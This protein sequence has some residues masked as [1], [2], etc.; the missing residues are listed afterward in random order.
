[1]SDGMVFSAA[2]FKADNIESY[3]EGAETLIVRVHYM[4][5][6]KD[7]R[8]VSQAIVH[9]EVALFESL[10]QRPVWQACYNDEESEL[11]AE[12]VSRHGYDLDD[13]IWYPIRESLRPYRRR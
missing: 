6:Q 12:E 5:C 4:G 1:M 7:E 9:Y 10:Q 3:S 13:T 2:E 11:F 8:G